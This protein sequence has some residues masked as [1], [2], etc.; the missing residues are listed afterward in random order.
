MFEDHADD[1]IADATESDYKVM[2]PV[3]LLKNV[4]LDI[5]NMKLS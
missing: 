2:L 1:L 3:H 4:R 5:Q